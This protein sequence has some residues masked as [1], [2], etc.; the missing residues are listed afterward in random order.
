[1]YKGTTP[2]EANSRL[3]SQRRGKDSF[4]ERCY[5]VLRQIP[6]GKVATYKQI[7]I[8]MNNPK[9]ARAVGN[10]CRKNPHI[11]NV[12]CH[13]VVCSNGALGEYVLGKVQKK[14]LLVS[15]GIEISEDGFVNLAVF[16]WNGITNR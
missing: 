2:Q 10:A 14:R 3:H 13:R 9:A 15:E 7:A 11:P 12:P 1:M 5:Q 4:N 6:A 8:A 16:G